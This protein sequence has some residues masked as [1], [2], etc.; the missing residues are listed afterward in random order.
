[1]FKSIRTK[2][3]TYFSIIIIFIS[4]VLG[5]MGYTSSMKTLNKTIDEQLLETSKAYS[6]N[7]NELIIDRKSFVERLSNMDSIKT[8]DWETQKQVL[9]FEVEN[10][11]DF[12]DLFIVDKKG[13]A[14][15]LDGT[16]MNVSDYRY[17]KEAVGGNVYFSDLIPDIK[18]KTL[19]LFASAPIKNSSIDG[20]IVGIPDGM[21]LRNKVLEIKLKESGNAFIINNQGTTIAHPDI[22]KVINQENIINNAKDNSEL[23]QV[24]NVITKMTQG[25]WGVDRY[26]YNGEKIYCGY[27]PIKDTGWSLAIKVPQKEVKKDIDAFRRNLIIFL[28]IINIV[29]I[30]IIYFVGSIFIKPVL[31]ATDYAKEI[32][33]LDLTKEIPS[34]YLNAKDEV[35]DLVRAFQTITE[36]TKK[37]IVEIYNSSN[38]LVHSSESLADIINENAVTSEE[39]AKVIQG[40]AIGANKQASESQEAVKELSNLG[41]FINDLNVIANGVNDSTVEVTKITTDG[42]KLLAKLKSEFGLNVK[43]AEQVK[44]N[45]KELALQSKSIADI[46]N[47]ISNIASQTNLLALNASIEAARAGES[48]RGFAV[49]ADEIR[50]L[51]EETEKATANISRILGTMTDGID[52]AN[53]NV[54]EASKIVENVDRYLEDT[55]AAYQVIETSSDEVIG[56]FRKVMSSLQLIEQNKVKTF[57]SVENIL[58]VSQESAASTEEVNASVEEQNATMENIAK[59]SEELAR[60]ANRM[61]N[62]IEKFKY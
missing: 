6:S 20:V 48:G 32:S 52:V 14:K 15:F 46:L 41:N 49:V 58:T 39:I 60:I 50:V 27:H 24:A 26:T 35:G 22:E 45:T 62:I 11:K 61:E 8:M 9:K 29:A 16:T 18:N 17:F 33:K 28:T 5:M 34:I 13:N 2:L 37:V 19:S 43:M 54:D 38:E 40:I 44:H 59:S 42:N 4:T 47:T 10:N 36:N 30:I 21:V 25:M 57:T 7:I 55:I 23:E 3:I 1:M 53:E 51:S 31:I 56:Q 12:I